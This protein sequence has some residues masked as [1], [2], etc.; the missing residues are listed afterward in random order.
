MSSLKT[1]VVSDSPISKQ[2]V[3]N[4]LINSIYNYFNVDDLLETE[5]T[6]CH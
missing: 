2:T 1:F 4:S 3:E 5:Y 6:A